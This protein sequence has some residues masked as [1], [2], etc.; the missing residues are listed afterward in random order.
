M[1]RILFAALAGC[2]AL[3]VWALVS[4]AILPWPL[5][6]VGPVAPPSSALTA[7]APARVIYSAGTSSAFDPAPSSAA[8]TEAEETPPLPH[9]GYYRTAAQP[10]AAA[11]SWD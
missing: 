10:P 3:R 1:L 11:V 9:R 2:V 5:I 6:S 4:A 7:L 8:T